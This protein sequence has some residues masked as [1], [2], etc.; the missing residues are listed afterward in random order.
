M[1]TRS[2]DMFVPYKIKELL[3]ATLLGNTNTYYIN[4]WSCMHFISGTISGYIYIYLGY[5]P[6]KYYYK[7]F[8]LHTI[9]ELWQMLVGSANPLKWKGDSGLADTMVD[10]I[11]FMVGSYVIK[12]IMLINRL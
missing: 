5:S 6:V 3:D 10:T 1:L 12:E 9:W 7:M 8:I 2:G 4:G 11:F